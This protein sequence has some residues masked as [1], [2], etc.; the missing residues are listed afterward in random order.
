MSTHTITVQAIKELPIDR[1]QVVSFESDNVGA[2][3]AAL[4]LCQIQEAIDEVCRYLGYAANIEERELTRSYVKVNLRTE[5][6][7]QLYY[8]MNMM[9]ERGIINYNPATIE[10]ILFGAESCEKWTEFGGRIYPGQ[11]QRSWSLS[12]HVQGGIKWQPYIF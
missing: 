11:T 6:P 10:G 4:T 5:D 1:Q 12:E 2:I 9:V 7:E 3:N 8:A